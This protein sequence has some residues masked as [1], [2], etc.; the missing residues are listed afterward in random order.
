MELT[1]ITPEGILCNMQ[2]DKASIPGSEGSFTVMSNHAPLMSTLR[3]GKIRYNA[4]GGGEKE[5]EVEDGIVEVKHNQI[6][7]F[8]EGGSN[9]TGSSNLA[10]GE[11]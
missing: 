10:Q 1:V 3:K 7:V 2:V 6:W 5:I 4:K 8:T 9:T 11:A